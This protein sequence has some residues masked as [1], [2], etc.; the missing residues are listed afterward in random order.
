MKSEEKFK[1][2][3]NSRRGNYAMNNREPL[4]SISYFIFH[5]SYLKRKSFRFTLIELLVVIAI[6]AILAGM[7]LPALNRARDQAR[8]VNCLSNQKQIGLSFASYVDDSRDYFPKVNLT[9]LNTSN[10]SGAGTWIG[11]LSAN[12]YMI[13]KPGILNCP[14]YDRKK[15]NFEKHYRSTASGTEKPYYAANFPAY[16]Y[17]RRVGSTFLSH[18]ATEDAD[19]YPPLKAPQIRRSPSQLLVTVDSY[20]RQGKAVPAEDAPGIYLIDDAHY[21]W[22]EPDA[23]RHNRNVSVLWADFHVSSLRI[24]LPDNPYLTI[25]KGTQTGSILNPLR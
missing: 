7:L 10:G 22:N 2:R 24:P 12:G 15:T 1:I 4:P 6:I 5:I 19:I 3:K 23:R 17:N 14:F 16:G 13:F 21:K 20:N 8:Q 25:L 18:G 11:V 9:S